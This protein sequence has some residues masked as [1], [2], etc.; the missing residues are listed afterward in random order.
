VHDNNFFGIDTPKQPSFAVVPV[1]LDRIAKL[2]HTRAATSR[3]ACAK[4]RRQGLSNER[5]AE[6]R[7]LMT[8]G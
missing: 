6:A 2:E 5:F 4:L 8:E 1:L 7:Q 3:D